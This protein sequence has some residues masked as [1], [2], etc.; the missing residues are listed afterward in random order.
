MKGKGK[1]R[2]AEQIRKEWNPKDH[3]CPICGLGFLEEV[4]RHSVLEARQRLNNNVL[5][6]RIEM[7]TKKESK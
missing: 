6:A 4:C 2:K 7:L 5:Q 3:K 1:L